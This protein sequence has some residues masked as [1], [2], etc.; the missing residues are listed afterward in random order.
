MKRAVVF[1]VTGQDGSYLSELLLSKGYK[2]VGVARR[3]SSDNTTRIAHLLSERRFKL[4]QGDVT[5][6]SSIHRIITKT[7]PHEV[8][9]LAAQSHVWTSFNQPVTTWDITGQGCLNI[10]E[11]IRNME[12]RPKFYQASSSEMFGDCYDCYD[13][14]CAERYQDEETSMNPQS[15]Y[16]VSKLAAYHLTKLYRRSYGIYTCNGIL[17]NHESE[18]RGDSFLTKKVSRYVSDLHFAKGEGRSIPKL[19]LGNLYSMRDWGHAED[20]VY[21]MWLMMQQDRSNDYVISTGLTH[22]VEEYVIEAF[23]C[24][25]IYEYTDY[26]EIDQSLYRPSEVAYLRGDY[27]KAKEYLGWEPKIPFKQLVQRMVNHD[28]Q[29]RLQYGE[30][31]IKA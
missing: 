8:Y 5:D 21:A 7:V 31:A 17:F 30:G 14:E 29:S 26:V 11:V 22:T 20:Y 19:K 9:N 24:I 13:D 27:G 25:N 15:P 23:K 2:V 12:R 4:V 3:S 16:A 1:G 18:R 28:I 10:L 6:M